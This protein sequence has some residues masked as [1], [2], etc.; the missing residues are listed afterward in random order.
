MSKKIAEGTGGAGARRQGRFGRVH[1]GPRQAPASWRETMVGLG[2][3]AGVR[4]VALLTDMST[5]LGLTAGNALE[6][7]ESVEVLAGGGPADVVELTVALAREMLAA[8]GLADVDPADALRDGRAMDAWRR[9][10]RRPGRR[11]GGA[12]ARGPGDP[13]GARAGHRGAHPA[14]RPRGRGGRLAA[15]RRPGPQGGPGAG[16]RRR[17]DARQAGRPGRRGSAAAHLAHR[18]AGA[19]RARG[20]RP[21]GRYRGGRP[22]SSYAPTPIVLD[23]VSP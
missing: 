9:D 11:P 17:A 2:A 21:R 12:A 6:V 22:G 8:A 23:R 20:G 1:E 19:F 3:E 14:G 15:G 16:R 10:D 5:P 13:R 7:A 18:R 4:T